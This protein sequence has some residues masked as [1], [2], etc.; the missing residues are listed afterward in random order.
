MNCLKVRENIKAYIDEELGPIARMRVE[1]HLDSC[2]KC[3]E[4]MIAMTDLTA[5]VQ[6]QPG[7]PT[8]DGLRAK[9]LGNMEF[10]P[11]PAAKKWWPYATSPA[12]LVLVLIV[13]VTLAA[14]LFPVFSKARRSSSAYLAQ[15]A[16]DRMVSSAPKGNAQLGGG[17][18]SAPA[19]APS[20][21]SAKRTRFAG[22]ADVFLPSAGQRS[23]QAARAQASDPNLMIIKTADISVQ[24]KSFDSAYDAAVAIGKSTG[25][26][27]T[28]SSADTTGNEPTS[29][30][31]TIRVPVGA[32]ERTVARLGKLG[33]VMNKSISGEDVTGEAVD[34]ESRLRN[35]RAEEQQYLEIMNRARRIADIVT[36]TNELSRVRGEI[37]EAQGRLKFLK[38]SSAMSTISLSLAEKSKPK[39][40]PSALGGA[41]SGAVGS[42]VEF[43]TDLAT[44]LIWL[45]VY[46]PFWAL[47]IAIAVYLK[48]KRAVAAQQP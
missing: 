25:G 6:G 20:P 40:A 9:V 8:P 22:D 31:L 17:P 4:E 10:Q 43:L 48:K 27:V 21:D 16:R 26:Y 38:S 46:S 32:F 45:A 35:K 36:V 19:G 30:R 11:Q 23:H 47:P 7:A 5:K 15:S 39:P 33:K 37:E 3:R 2:E 1:R 18:V 29:G 28:D 34:L 41:F 42:F 44:I 13:C 14:V 24:V 12:S